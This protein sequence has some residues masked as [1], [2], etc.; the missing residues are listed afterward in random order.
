MSHAMAEGPERI[1]LVLQSEGDVPAGDAWLSPSELRTLASLR[2]PKRSR[3]WRLGRWTAKLAIRRC[4]GRE[5]DRSTSEDDAQPQDLGDVTIE[6]ARDG[7]PEALDG[8]QRRLP[9]S[10]SISHSNGWSLCAAGRPGL[11]LGCDLERIEPRSPALTAD[12]FTEPERH[13]ASEGDADQRALATT[14]IWSAKESAL[15]AVRAGLRL[16][17]RSMEVELGR[18]IGS[19]GTWQ[20]FVVREAPGSRAFHGW[21]LQRDDF[22]LTVAAHPAPAIPE[23]DLMWAQAG[24]GAASSRSTHE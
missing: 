11:D 23:L 14:L 22:V 6:A 12:F 2:H 9:V 3:D 5:A 8:D 1:H 15:K 21:W 24:A 7:A 13:V 16:D 19:R 20:P 18:P 10:L 4:L 17:T